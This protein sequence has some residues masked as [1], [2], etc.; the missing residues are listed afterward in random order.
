MFK[1]IALITALTVATGSAAFAEEYLET[2]GS[3]NAPAYQTAPAQSVPTPFRELRLEQ[4]SYR[5]VEQRSHRGE[6]PVPAYQPSGAEQAAKDR[7]LTIM[8][9]GG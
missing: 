5:G 1:K 9:H 6:A 7:A 2:T 3:R 8:G 4:R